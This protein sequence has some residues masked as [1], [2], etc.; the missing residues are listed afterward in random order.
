[1]IESLLPPELGPLVATAL[2]GVSFLGSFIT[3]AFGIGGGVV[4]LAVFAS[5]LSP[6]A[7]IPVHGVIQLGSNAGRMLIMREYISWPVF[8]PFVVG[9]LVGVAIGGIVVV[10][11]PPAVIQIAV[12]L[13]ILWTIVAKPPAFLRHSAWLAG[14][15]S[16]FLTMFFGATGPFVAAY[17]KTLGVERMVHV[18]TQAACMTMQ[19]GLKVVAFGILGFAFGP[20]IALI[21]GM[22][23]FGFLGTL[24]GRKVLMKIDEKF[25]KT[26]LNA[27]LILLS[28]RLIW[29]GVSTYL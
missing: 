29:A 3:A 24:V 5:L 1:M 20:Y 22:I 4:V 23:A 10:D 25:F 8:I 27:I 17:I 18:G 9:A 15:F 28:L 12:G 7:L 21:V 19:H 13:F 14:G 26:I 11:L 16:S 2:L 6:A